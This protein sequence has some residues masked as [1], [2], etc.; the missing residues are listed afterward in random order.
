MSK[1]PS[2]RNLAKN[3]AKT[4]RTR[5]KTIALRDWIN[6]CTAIFLERYERQLAWWQRASRKPIVYFPSIVLR[7]GSIWVGVVNHLAV[8][9][10]LESARRLFRQVQ[11]ASKT[12]TPRIESLEERVV[13]AHFQVLEVP[14][15]RPAGDARIFV[16][17]PGTASGSSASYSIDMTA[18]QGSRYPE[19]PDGTRWNHSNGSFTL[20]GA[21]TVTIIPDPGEQIG[22]LV[23]IDL[24]AAYSVSGGTGAGVSEGHT[25]TGW[26]ISVHVYGPTGTP[27]GGAGQ[28]SLFSGH[29]SAKLINESPTSQITDFDVS[30]STKRS[31]EA[32]IGDRVSIP[33]SLFGRAATWQGGFTGLARGAVTGGISYSINVTRYAPDLSIKVTPNTSTKTLDVA[34]QFDSWGGG[35]ATRDAALDLYWI[36]IQDGEEIRRGDPF[37]ST[38]VPVAS[39]TKGTLPIPVSVIGQLLPG[40]WADR[41]EFVAANPD[42]PKKSLG[43][44]LNTNNFAKIDLYAAPTV[45]LTFAPVHAVPGIGVPVQFEKEPYQVFVSVQNNSLVEADFDIVLDVN[46]LGE[47]PPELKDAPNFTGLDADNIPALGSTPKKILVASPMQDWDWIPDENPMSNIRLRNYLLPSGWGPEDWGALVD[48]MLGEVPGLFGKAYTVF[49]YINGTAEALADFAYR[50]EDGKLIKTYE[51]MAMLYTAAVSTN[52]LYVGDV[53]TVTVKEGVFVRVPPKRLS[54]FDKFLG[55]RLTADLA[56]PEGLGFIIEGILD[57]SQKKL[58]LG[59]VTLAAGM[60]AFQT[61]Q[62]AYDQAKD[63]PDPN[64]TVIAQPQ[65]IR[66]SALDGRETSLTTGLALARSEVLALHQAQAVSRDRADGAREAADF[67]WEERQA[68]ASAGYAAKAA[69]RLVDVGIAETLLIPFSE[70]AVMPAAADIRN[71]LAAN[72]LPPEVQSV[73]D[74]FRVSQADQDQLLSDAL[75]IELPAG[76]PAYD[77]ALALINLT[78]TASIAM[79]ELESAIRVRTEALGLN[80]SAV[81]AADRSRLDATRDA[82]HANLN[83]YATSG[84]NLRRVSDYLAQVQDLILRTNNF[85]GLRE[86]LNFGYAA[87][88]RIQTADWSFAGFRSYLDLA[89]VEEKIPADAAAQFDSVLLGAETAMREGRFADAVVSLDVAMGE[90][91]NRWVRSMQL[92]VAVQLAD[93]LSIVHGLLSGAFITPSLA[94]VS[95]MVGVSGAGSVLIDVMANDSAP[96]GGQ[97][98][99]LAVAAPQHGTATVDDGGTPGDPTDDRVTY[100][101]GPSFSGADSFDYYVN[102]DRVVGV[103]SGQVS[104]RRELAVGEEYS[105]AIP[106]LVTQSFFLQAEAGKWYRLETLD[107]SGYVAVEITAPDESFVSSGVAQNSSLIPFLAGLSGEYRVQFES[108]FGGSVTFRLVE[109]PGVEITMEQEYGDSLPQNDLQ[110]YTFQAEAGNWYRLQTLTATGA[111]ATAEVYNTDRSHITTGTLFS[112]GQMLFYAPTTGPYEIVL[113]NES[114]YGGTAEFTFRLVLIDGLKEIIRGQSDTGTLNPPPDGAGRSEILYRLKVTAGESFR[115]MLPPSSSYE[116]NIGAYGPGGALLGSVSYYSREVVVRPQTSGEVLIAVYGS[117]FSNPVE[118]QFI[119]ATPL[120][121]RRTI[122][123]GD[124]VTGSVAGTADRH[125]YTF[126]GSSGMQML[127]DQSAS[128]NVSFNLHRPD[129]QKTQIYSGLE[130]LLADGQYELEVLSVRGASDYRI[131]L[132]EAAV[133]T[134]IAVGEEVSITFNRPTEWAVP[135]QLLY[136]VSLTEGQELVLNTTE[137]PAS[138]AGQGFWSLLGPDATFVGGG[139]LRDS[140]LF[141]VPATGTYFLLVEAFEETA[142]SFLF[143]LQPEPISFDLNLGEAITGSIDMPGRLAKFTFIGSAG[144]SLYYEALDRD[145]DRIVARLRGPDGR[146]LWYANADLDGLLVLP[147]DGDYVLEIDAQDADAGD[148]SF[149]LSELSNPPLLSVGQIV[150]GVIDPP[151]STVVYAFDGLADQRLLFDNLSA[152]ETKGGNWILYGPDGWNLN[153]YNDS[154]GTDFAV[155]LP[156]TGRYFLALEGRSENAITYEFKVTEPV[157]VARPLTLGIMTSGE[158]VEAGERHVYTFTGSIGQILYYDSIDADLEPTLLR[159]I[160]PDG[161]VVA[162]FAGEVDGPAFVLPMAGEYRL[163]VTNSSILPGDYA[164]RM[165]NVSAQTAVPLGEP[166]TGVV[167]WQTGNPEGSASSAYRLSVP[168]ATE[169]ILNFALFSN[170][171]PYVS[172]TVYD[173]STATKLYSRDSIFSNANISFPRAGEY[174]LVFEGASGESVD[175][176]FQVDSINHAPTSLSLS[177]SF[178]NQD[179]PEGTAIGQLSTS[180]ADPTDIHSYAIVIGQG[181]SDNAKFSIVGN[182]LRAATTLNFATGSFYTIRIRTTDQSGLSLEQQVLIRAM[183]IANNDTA[184]VLSNSSITVDV[185]DNDL[186]SLGNTLVIVDQALSAGSATVVGDS[187]LFNPSDE[188]RGIARFTYQ[189]Q[190]APG[191]FSNTSTV[192]IG[193]AGSARQNPWMILDVDSDGNISPLDVLVIIN[194]LNSYGPSIPVEILGNSIEKPFYDT[195]GDGFISPLDVLSVINHLNSRSKG[196]G[197]EASV[198]DYPTDVDISL[199]DTAFGDTWDWL[200]NT[201]RR[202][203]SRSHS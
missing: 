37:Y 68:L 136:K 24:N 103:A 202:R 29:R 95:E 55:F 2:N 129:G 104:V 67:A 61:A 27:A 128:G 176:R 57:G 166:V 74:D 165:L 58:D 147:L 18:G 161:D 97:L 9:L 11:F 20:G 1:N 84:L 137:T 99:L 30:T 19:I 132:R 60:Y 190:I 184:T 3:R 163:S 94:V 38:T 91:L 119:V 197:E 199:I 186:H 93:T 42:D 102:G 14:V 72:G 23:R 5:Q 198:I 66:I 122:A 143:A 155:T 191:V 148:F 159:L 76:D 32:R 108:Y 115:L 106:G 43:E 31:F 26:D 118:Y 168:N 8:S 22:N 139:D 179:A 146:L 83:T 194:L 90:T 10:K 87:L 167:E 53:P 33:T 193:V 200:S 121:E 36:D 152:S 173:A 180:D 48:F 41:V 52:S 73:L 64:Y 50:A 79:G 134:T 117:N 151:R 203:G 175:F 145:F 86:Y 16:Q 69:L 133:Q 65:P 135:D 130:T 78:R 177:N 44:T 80:V 162:A 170:P 71:Y 141:T 124:I 81:E 39:S 140:L 21:F 34:Y 172:W 138:S 28:G 56:I 101:P 201:R 47:V 105:L 109:V 7:V 62:T 181:D 153:K 142:F 195:D 120:T 6:S 182:Q 187:I 189:L 40:G 13:L 169:W 45:E 150:S 178:V 192:S 127:L 25:D 51:Q 114:Y 107:A 92:P 4:V 157:T 98:R 77:Y 113:S 17:D 125:F 63:P 82:L 100:T 70:T 164:F 59:T 131:R 174:V 110:P 46:S 12:F 112:G 188:F 123:I 183:P 154:L 89:V 111:R 15:A 88:F 160:G 126:T 54:Q 196:E 75:A 144:L 96:L 35:T 185:K 149:R 85:E 158:I 49:S 116:V 171:D 156:K